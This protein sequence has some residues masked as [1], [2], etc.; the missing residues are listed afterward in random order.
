MNLRFADF[1][2][3]KL[4]VAVV[5]LGYVGLPLAVSLAGHFAVI[6]FDVSEERVASLAMGRDHT[7]EVTT[8][9]NKVI[10]E[11]I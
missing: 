9:R 4:P 8:S 11:T 1:K 10:S 5:G 2:K 7:G 6:G 3:K